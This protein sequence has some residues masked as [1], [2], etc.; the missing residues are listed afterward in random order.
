LD[1]GSI[2]IVTDPVNG[3]VVPLADGTVR[4]APNDGFLGIDTFRYTIAD[5]EGR[6]SSP[7]LVQVR[8]LASRLQ[9]PDLN[10]DVNDDGDISPID[11]LLVINRIGRDGGDSIPVTGEDSGP[12]FYDV[13]GDQRITPLDALAVINELALRAAASGESEFVVA[14]FAGVSDDDSEESADGPLPAEAGSTVAASTDPI[15]T[16]DTADA[17]GQQAGDA[18][19]DLLANGSNADDD[20]DRLEALDAAFGDLI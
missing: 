18:V 11:A 5:S 7:G 10:P 1:L 8:V 17:T 6:T 19:I 14:P 16:F 3:S 9:N 13:N 15:A 20:E 4:Y 12:P 2:Q